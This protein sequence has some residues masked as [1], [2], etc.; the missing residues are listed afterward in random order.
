MPTLVIEVPPNDIGGDA[1]PE[2]K[3]HDG[4]S[5]KPREDNVEGGR[6]ATRDKRGDLHTFGPGMHEV[7]DEIAAV[8]RNEDL[9]WLHVLDDGLD[10]Y[11]FN[12]FD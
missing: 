9:P 2:R 11:G 12:D 7:T 3:P 1:H 10:D 6:W 5:G 8:A 4:T